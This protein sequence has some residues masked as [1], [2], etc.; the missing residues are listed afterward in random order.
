M[1]VHQNNTIVVGTRKIKASCDKYEKLHIIRMAPSVAIVGAGVGGLCMGALLARDGYSVTV[2]EKD[3][4]VGGRTASTTHK[5]HTLDN[6]FHIMPFYKK[7]ALYHVLSMI[8][9]RNKTGLVPVSNIAFHSK[10]QFHRYPT[11]ILD[12]LR[13]GL[14]PFRSRVV[15]LQILLP[16]AFSS[17]AS[18][19]EKDGMSLSSITTNMDRRTR[20][21]FDAICMLAFA[22]TPD[23]VSLGEFVRTIIRANPFRGGT[24]RFAYPSKGYD[25][26]CKSLA[27]YIKNKGGH[28]LLSSAIQKIKIRQGAV[29][30]V[31]DS[32]DNT[33]KSDCVIASPPAYQIPRLL[34]D[35]ILNDDTKRRIS[36]LKSS[37]AVVEV[38]YATN[39]QIDTRQIVFP[40]GKY[41]AKGIFFT[42]NISP[43]LCPADEHQII[44][45]APVN[46]DAITGAKLRQTATKMRQD[47][48]SIY[49]G[50]E[51]SILWERPMAWSLVE[52]VAKMP[53]MVWRSKMPHHISEVRGL[54]FVGDST[55]SY[56]IGTDS[57]AHSAL[58][59]YPNVKAHLSSRSTIV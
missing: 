36:N 43:R 5:R 26:V 25:T 59:C 11:G 46:S 53:G 14:V 24:S 7:S 37:T 18:A 17:M 35:N 13:M 49:T 3:Q 1:L 56:G 22:D 33:L 51:N 40:V 58:L 47:L 45:G 23:R 28:V 44:C 8:G 34:D 20:A 48:E 31:T 9:I 2:F 16:M 54:F 30:G 39:R 27:A 57:A 41:T 4:K 12:I 38:H 52:S 55:I 21:F 42:S 15:L 50:F 19:E 6:G 29:Y 32:N 10:G